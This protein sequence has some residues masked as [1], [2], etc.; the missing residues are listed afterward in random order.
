MKDL[1]TYRVWWAMVARCTD[2][3][4]DSYEYYG[5]KGVC[6]YPPWIESFDN[7]VDDLGLRPDMEHTLDRIDPTGHY[8]PENCR[9][10][11][12]DV[13][14]NNKTTSRFIEHDGLRLTHTQWSRRLGGGSSLVRDRVRRGWSLHEA[15]TLRKGQKKKAS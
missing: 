5:G 10:T 6:V 9:W 8:Y 2:P 15:V 7:F 3:G 12:W 13:Q 4:R 11:T 1:P 14:H